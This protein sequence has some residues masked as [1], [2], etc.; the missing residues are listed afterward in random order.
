MKVR[1]DKEDKKYFTMAEAP[2]VSAVI[3]DMKES[4]ETIENAVKYATHALDMYD[5]Y[6]I[7]K[8]SAKV[9]HNSNVWNYYSEESGTIDIWIDATLETDD[10]FYIIGFYLSDSWS[11]TCE[12]ENHKEIA[13]HMYVRKF[14]EVE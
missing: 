4:E 5:S 7:L 12:D 11:V 13:R 6:E 3:K 1:F 14:V 8:S 2:V 10:T 9:D